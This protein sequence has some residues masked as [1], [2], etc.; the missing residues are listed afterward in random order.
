MNQPRSEAGCQGKPWFMYQ[1]ILS[2]IGIL[3]SE[4]ISFYP[5]SEKKKIKRKRKKGKKK[6]LLVGAAGADM[7]IMRTQA[8][9]TDCHLPEKCPKLDGAGR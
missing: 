9:A 7:N 8:Q 6:L 5:L 2:N 4:G 3:G 1:H